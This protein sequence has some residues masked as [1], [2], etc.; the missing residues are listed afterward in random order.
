MNSRYHWRAYLVYLFLVLIVCGL[1]WRLIDL[2]LVNRFF[3]LKQSDARILRT[4]TLVAHRGV[5]TDRDGTVLAMSTPVYS[6]WVNPKYFQA[7]HSQLNAL[8]HTLEL[9]VAMIKSRVNPAS[10]KEFVYL[11]R[12]NSPDVKEAIKILAIHGVHFQQEYQRFYPE[13]EV[14][15]HVLGIT[16]VD[17]QGQEGLELAYNSWLSGVPG[18]KEVLKDRLGNVIADVALLK[19]PQEGRDLT[20]SIDHRIQYVAYRQS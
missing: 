10:G 1:I 18:K 20:L 14:I 19:K 3:L 4:E 11:K 9:P 13:G 5:I 15:A 16:N 6:V 8:A 7:T 2:N 17:D 12:Q